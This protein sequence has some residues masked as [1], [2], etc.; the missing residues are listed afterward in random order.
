MIRHSPPKSNSI[1]DNSQLSSRFGG[2]EAGCDR[3]HP[4]GKVGHGGVGVDRSPGQRGLAAIACKCG[5]ASKPCKPKGSMHLPRN[6]ATLC[7]TRRRRDK[8]AVDQHFLLRSIAPR[9]LPA[10]HS[11]ERP[12]PA[13]AIRGRRRCGAC[14]RGTRNRARWL[15]PPRDRAV[16]PPK[17]A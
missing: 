12:A 13:P 1:V 8:L 2:R 16:F 4:E 9:R 15:A 7:E 11:G 5:R 6:L 10:R 14:R 3:T 17:P